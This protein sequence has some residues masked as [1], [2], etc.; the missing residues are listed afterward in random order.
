VVHAPVRA[1]PTSG[2]VAQTRTPSP[3]DALANIQIQRQGAAP[4][5]IDA[6]APASSTP[7]Q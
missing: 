5:R 1:A 3:A 7:Q 2:R 6:T 4:P